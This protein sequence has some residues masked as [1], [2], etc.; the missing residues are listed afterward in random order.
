MA[1]LSRGVVNH[2]NE[3]KQGWAVDNLDPGR[4]IES[5][6]TLTDLLNPLEPFD[7]FQSGFC[8]LLKIE[9]ITIEVPVDSLDS[10]HFS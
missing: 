7:L 6:E 9:Q 3:W 5:Q 4:S 1:P 2:L 8:S 10:F